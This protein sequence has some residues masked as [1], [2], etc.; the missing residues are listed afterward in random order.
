MCQGVEQSGCDASG[1]YLIKEHLR[2]L[3]REGGQVM[4]R[5]AVILKGEYNV[6]RRGVLLLLPSGEKVALKGGLLNC[7]K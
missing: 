3:D 6:K 1:T 4:P 7:Y 5:T 2:T